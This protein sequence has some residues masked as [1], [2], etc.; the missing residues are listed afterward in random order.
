MKILRKCFT[1]YN[2]DKFKPVIIASEYMH[3]EFN[4]FSYL[5]P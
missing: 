3:I 4:L 2:F 5:F 1:S